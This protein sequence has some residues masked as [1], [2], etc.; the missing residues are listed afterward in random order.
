MR[1]LP[2]IYLVGGQP[3]GLS[4]RYDCSIYVVKAPDGL[5]MID[6]G[7]GR[8]PEAII[9]NMREERLDPAH[10]R[11]LLLTHH[12]TDH[13]SGAAAIRELT[14]CKV[15]ISER[16]AHLLEHGTEL[17][18]RLDLA[19]RMGVYPEDFIWHNCAVDRRLHDGETPSLAGLTVQVVEVEGHSVDSCCFLM[20]LDGRR[21]LFVGDVLQYGGVLGLLNFPGSSLD[22][23]RNALPKLRGLRVDA[24][25]P[26]HSLF[27][28]K[29][30]QWHI[31]R[32]L[33]RIK[34]AY[35]PPTVGQQVWM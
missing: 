34:S 32:A 25:F 33:E 4:D 9:G 5:V 2:S 28:V 29:N 35:V 15:A 21:C 7:G 27:T 10:L 8:D 17:D 24:F 14:G 30:G 23:Y 13:A 11:W 22:G 19:K 3:T 6:A 12:H 16:T 1:L 31:D 18:V 20:E 26:G